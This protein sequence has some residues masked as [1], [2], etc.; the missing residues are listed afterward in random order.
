M[1]GVTQ[2]LATY[3]S[4]QLLSFEMM[5]FRLSTRLFALM[6]G[7]FGFRSLS[8]ADSEVPGFS[9]AMLMFSSSVRSGNGNESRRLEKSSNR[10][11]RKLRARKWR[12]VSLKLNRTSETRR[13]SPSSE[14]KK[15][16]CLLELFSSTDRRSPVRDG[17]RCELVLLTSALESGTMMLSHARSV[18]EFTRENKI[19]FALQCSS[20]TTCT[21]GCRMSVG[22]QHVALPSTA[23]LKEVPATDV[24]T[25]EN[26][27]LRTNA[28]PSHGTMHRIFSSEA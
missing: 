2:T 7:T 11:M 22:F 6:S 13:D 24:L 27:T 8:A 4:V 19:S 25:W 14:L 28:S 3:T 26:I 20:S 5:A 10:C 16:W 15:Y 12:K 9:K 1:S 18:Q 23:I 17:V 21:Y